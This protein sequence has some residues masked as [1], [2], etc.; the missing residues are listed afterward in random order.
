MI[1]V[2]DLTPLPEGRFVHLEGP[3]VHCPRCD[4]NGVL[5]TEPGGLRC[6]HAETVNVFCDGMR[7]DPTEWCELTNV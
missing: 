3:V 5:E 6:V 1:T 4:R 2:H 7:V